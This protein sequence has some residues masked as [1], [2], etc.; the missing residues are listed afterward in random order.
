MTG[1]WK[2]SEDNLQNRLQESET[3]NPIDYASESLWVPFPELSNS[4]LLSFK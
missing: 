4:S 3:P 2:N 1:D